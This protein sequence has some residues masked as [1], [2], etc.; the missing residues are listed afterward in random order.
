MADSISEDVCH[1]K[2]DD[3]GETKPL[4]N[5]V[6]DKSPEPQR[7]QP[8]LSLEDVLERIGVGFFHFLL[9]LVAGWALAS[10]SVEVQCI[11]FVTPKLDDDPHIHPS[12]V[13]TAMPASRRA[14]LSLIK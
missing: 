14:Q 5:S 7:S 6:R 9:I 8:R 13:R 12:K 4:M 11:S 10:D 1:D 3:R 2:P